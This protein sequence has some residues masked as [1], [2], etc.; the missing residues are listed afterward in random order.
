MVYD[1]TELG[2]RVVAPD[3]KETSKLLSDNRSREKTIRRLLN[4]KNRRKELPPSEKEAIR[5]ELD[6][7][8]SATN[9]IVGSVDLNTVGSEFLADIYSRL[10]EQ[11]K[12]LIELKTRV[13]D[14][15]SY[16]E[17]KKQLDVT[18]KK[19]QIPFAEEQEI[20]QRMNE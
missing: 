18:Q 9:K 11:G 4:S 15:I 16:E 12:T 7:K 6:E 19:W 17:L 1:Y 13:C 2:N 5:K 20:R 14:D 10:Y 3:V 8:I